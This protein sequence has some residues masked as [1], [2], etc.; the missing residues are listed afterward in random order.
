LVVEELQRHGADAPWES[1][2]DVA[3]SVVL[4]GEVEAACG[5]ATGR[6]SAVDVRPV[7]SQRRA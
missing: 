6:Q 4:S 7:W 1:T 5:I 2:F 3:F